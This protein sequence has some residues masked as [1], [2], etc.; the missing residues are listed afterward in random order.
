[1]YGDGW[2]TLACWWVERL[3]ERDAHVQLGTY[4]RDEETS[5]T[6]ALDTW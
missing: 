4:V 1:M 2:T 5:Q 3:D 6:G